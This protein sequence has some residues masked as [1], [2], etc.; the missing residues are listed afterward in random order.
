MLSVS[1]KQLLFK[2]KDKYLKGLS[3][4]TASRAHL[5]DGVGSQD[6]LLYIG[7]AGGAAD[8]GK[9]PHGVFG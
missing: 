3:Q 9:V 4:Q 8:R 6:F 1:R 2:I 5:H 7:L